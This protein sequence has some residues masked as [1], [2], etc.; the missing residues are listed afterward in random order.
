MPDARYAQRI[1][2]LEHE[3]DSAY[4]ESSRSSQEQQ[5]VDEAPSLLEPHDSGETF[6]AESYEDELKMFISN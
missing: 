5:S 3:V 4:C 2:D 1:N 6:A